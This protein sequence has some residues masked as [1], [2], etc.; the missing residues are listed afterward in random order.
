MTAWLLV[1]ATKRFYKPE[2]VLAGIM[3]GVAIAGLFFNLIQLFILGG[4]GH[5]HDHDHGDGHGHG[6][7][8]DA[9]VRY[10]P[11]ELNDA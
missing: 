1:E 2:E 6:H 10:H 3:M 11:R 5:S 4:H 7:S 8:H 9:P